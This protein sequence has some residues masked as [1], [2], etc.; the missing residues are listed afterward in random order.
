MAQVLSG[1]PEVVYYIDDILVTRH[2]RA[3]YT[4]NLQAVLESMACN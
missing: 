1:L 3:E 2:M 4:T